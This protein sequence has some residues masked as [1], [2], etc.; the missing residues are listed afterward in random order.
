MKTSKQK[1]LTKFLKLA[2][3]EST[4]S[5]KDVLKDLSKKKQYNLNRKK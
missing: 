2:S 1:V 3:K 4:Q 5:I